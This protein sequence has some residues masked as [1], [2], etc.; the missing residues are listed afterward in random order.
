MRHGRD[1]QE[2]EQ[3]LKQNRSNNTPEQQSFEAELLKGGRTGGIPNQRV[4]GSNEERF[5]PASELDEAEPVADGSEYAPTKQAEERERE[6][7]RQE[8]KL[9]RIAAGTGENVRDRRDPEVS[10]EDLEQAARAADEKV[11]GH[12]VHKQT[13]P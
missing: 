2:R 4:F 5:A 12:P 1:H 10:R 7:H 9:G 11:A 6:R 3:R 13:K 8:R